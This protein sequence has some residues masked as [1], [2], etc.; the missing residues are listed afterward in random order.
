LS[1]SDIVAIE[2]AL[3]ADRIIGT[4]YPEQQMARLG[5]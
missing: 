5:I 2:T 3:D 4:R 1:D